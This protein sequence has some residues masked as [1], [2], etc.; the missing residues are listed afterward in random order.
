MHH[1]DEAAV[2]TT[3][4]KWIGVSSIKGQLECYTGTLN[5]AVATPTDFLKLESF[6]AES[7]YAKSVIQDT[8][9]GFYILGMHDW[10][11]LVPH[12]FLALLTATISATPWIRWSRRFS[13]RT[14]L[15]ATTFL[16]VVLGLIVALR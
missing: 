1:L 8:A 13:L 3:A 11:V 6:D 5:P 7:G 9:W 12:W 2:P 10:Y 14:L 16:A 15:I 4:T